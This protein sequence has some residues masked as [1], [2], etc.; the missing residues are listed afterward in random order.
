MVRSLPLTP[1]DTGLE[2]IVGFT[3]GLEP[4][5]RG[6]Q[7]T[8]EAVLDGLERAMR[9]DYRDGAKQTVIVIGDAA[10]HRGEEAAT[11]A[12]ARRFAASGERRTISPLF[13]TTEAYLRYGEG[14][15]GFFMSL[16]EAGGGAFSDHSGEMMEAV[17]LSVLED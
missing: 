13:V 10:P 2:R 7:T 4:P 6:G 15:R 12:L 9:L 8:R 16:A 14:D 17:L 3:A 11:L 1:T 5:R